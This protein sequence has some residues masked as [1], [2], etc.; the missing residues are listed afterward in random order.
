[1]ALYAKPS[2]TL[3]SKMVISFSKAPFLGAW[4]YSFLS[5]SCI[6]QKSPQKKEEKKAN[7][8]SAELLKIRKVGAAEM[9]WVARTKRTVFTP[10][11]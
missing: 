4:D 9:S 6:K 7:G 10:V 2:M 11:I 3:L 1:M 8:L 5:V